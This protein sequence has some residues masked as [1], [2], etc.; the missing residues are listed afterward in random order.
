MDELHQRWE[1][2]S[3][4]PFPAS[5]HVSDM[6]LEMIDATIA[7]CVSTSVTT[8]TIEPENLS[9]LQESRDILASE[10]EKIPEDAKAYFHALWEMAE[11]LLKK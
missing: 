11:L 5:A 4:L 6:P 2:F 10:F 7:G 3:A 9:K 1:K 8:G